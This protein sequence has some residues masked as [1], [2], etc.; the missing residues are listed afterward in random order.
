[1]DRLWPEAFFL[2][3]RVLKNLFMMLLDVMLFRLVCNVFG[4]EPFQ[5][6]RCSSD[7]FVEK[8]RY[9]HRDGPGWPFMSRKTPLPEL[10]FKGTS[11]DNTIVTMLQ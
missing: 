8:E 11:S 9:H 4:S 6:N 3:K 7:E 10:L 2:P 5:L 1:M